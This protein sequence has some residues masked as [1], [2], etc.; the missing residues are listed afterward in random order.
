[1]YLMHIKPLTSLK[2]QPPGGEDHITADGLN[3][4][5]GARNIRKA[6]AAGM[7]GERRVEGA[8]WHTE[9]YG[10]HD[11][12]SADYAHEASGP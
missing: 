9:Q 2:W 3:L 6:D 5:P 10:I 8:Q 12:S 1:M 11:M 7:E 4:S